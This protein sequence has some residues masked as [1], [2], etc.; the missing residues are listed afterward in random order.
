MHLAR[1]V[2]PENFSIF[3]KTYIDVCKHPHSH[4]FLDFTQSINSLLRFKTKILPGDNTDMF[5]AVE[6]NEPVDVTVTLSPHT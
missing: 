2:Y 1:Q 3:H 6:A 5:A 4:L